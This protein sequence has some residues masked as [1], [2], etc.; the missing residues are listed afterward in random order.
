MDNYI[1]F[2]KLKSNEIMS[3]S[4]LESELKS[5]V[6][7]L[8]DFPRK[9]DG[10]TADLFKNTTSRL[11][12]SINKNLDGI[13]QFYLDNFDI[14]SNFEINGSC[15]YKYLID[16]FKDLPYIPV[17][18]IDRSDDHITAIA[19]KKESGGII[20]NIIAL[21]LLPADFESFDLTNQEISD[22]LTTILDLFDE[23]DLILDCRMCL[24]L[25]TKRLSKN[26]VSFV[27]EFTRAYSTRRVIFSGSSITASIGE[28]VKSG[29][30][31]NLLRVELDIFKSCCNELTSEKLNIYLGDY[32]IVSPNYSDI[33]IIPEAMQNITAPKIV[34]SFDDKHYIVRGG[35]LKTHP[36]GYKQYFDLSATIVSKPFYRGKNF[37]YGDQ[38]IEEKSR[39][40]GKNGTP[41][42]ILKPTINAHI[43]YM[44]KNYN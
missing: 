30:E 13:H 44:F 17:V 12:K 35:A 43:S 38:Y 15:S 41:S 4:T 18:S 21:R 37:S 20:S 7:P 31:T 24:G 27:K 3:L 2:L 29:E 34:Y 39:S 28:I 1:P 11:V 26:I 14:E 32:G 19:A 10:Y 25:D 8:F 42:S 22:L 5:R 36:R 40:A 16:A 6:T 23:I 9:K 33:D